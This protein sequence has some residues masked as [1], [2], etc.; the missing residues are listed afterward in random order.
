M[1]VITNHPPPSSMPSEKEIAFA[2]N[3][4]LDLV[5]RSNIHALHKIIELGDLVLKEISADLKEL[6][7]GVGVRV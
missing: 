3:P 4:A 7:A 5:E 1:Q 2:S 6:G